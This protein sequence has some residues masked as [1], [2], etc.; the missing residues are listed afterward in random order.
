MEHILVLLRLSRVLLLLLL[1]KFLVTLNCIS[2][3]I[4]TPTAENRQVSLKTRIYERGLRIVIANI[5]DL[6]SLITFQANSLIHL[7][8]LLRLHSVNTILIWWS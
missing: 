2:M 4:V 1:N 7:C 8:E 3:K 5:I 6:S